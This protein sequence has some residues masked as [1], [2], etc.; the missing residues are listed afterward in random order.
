MTNLFFAFV[1]S[2]AIGI[3]FR[4]PL[5]A[6]PGAGLTGLLGYAVYSLALQADAPQLLAVFLGGLM[7]GLA[8]ELL[9]RRLREPVLLFVV[10]GLFPLVPG[11]MAYNGMLMLTREQ[12]AE[13]GMLLARTMFYAGALAAGLALPPVL[14]RGIRQQTTV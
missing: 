6:I 2:A 11:L 3:S 7:V 4:G 5:R 8:G 13:S 14:I 1:T 12:L 10:P 9:A